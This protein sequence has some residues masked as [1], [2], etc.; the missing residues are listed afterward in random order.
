[1]RV[2][3]VWINLARSTDRAE[4]MTAHLAE[5]GVLA[6]RFDAI[7]GA[8]PLS[9]SIVERYRRYRRTLETTARPTD[10]CALSHLAVLEEARDHAGWTIVLEDD[11]RLAPDFVRMV[12]FVLA[13]T[14][15]DAALVWLH[16]CSG[17]VG[18][19]RWKRLVERTTPR[20]R[21]ALKWGGSLGLFVPPWWWTGGTWGYAV[22][23]EGAQRILEALESTQ[24]LEKEKHVDRAL[25]A[26]DLPAYGTT[27]VLVERSP[28]YRSSPHWDRRLRVE[29]WPAVDEWFQHWLARLAFHRHRRRTALS[30]APGVRA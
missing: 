11:A 2:R 17:V 4:W 1:V 26:L 8:K 6:E 27:S 10:G 16:R 18:Q 12:P 15:P 9:L 28:L 30:V 29:P 14:P 5:M 20:P 21:R 3:T 23:R 22:S 19:G 13:E 25:F 24:I 7:D